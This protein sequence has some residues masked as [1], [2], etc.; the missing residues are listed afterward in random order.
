MFNDFCNL[1]LNCECD[2][3]DGVVCPLDNESFPNKDRSLSRERHHALKKEQN[4]TKQ[5]VDIISSKNSRIPDKAPIEQRHRAVI[6]LKN[7]MHKVHQ[8]E[9]NQ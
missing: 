2:C 6:K 5:N 9:E 3:P 7:A 4:S 1:S 8:C